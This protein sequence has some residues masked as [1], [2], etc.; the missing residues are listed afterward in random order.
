MG[1]RK[2]I[3]LIL[4]YA[5]YDK[6]TNYKE[7][8]SVIDTS[9]AINAEG[10]K[11]ISRL[12]ETTFCT[13]FDACKLFLPASFNVKL[14]TRY[15]VNEEQFEAIKALL[16][17]EDTAELQAIRKTG[18][19]HD[20]N[21]KYLISQKLIF[22]EEYIDTPKVKTEK[23]VSLTE[24]YLTGE[25][26]YAFT[27]D[28]TR[29]AVEFLKNS[30]DIT[31]KELIR[32]FDISSASLKT[33]S[34]RGVVETTAV[35]AAARRSVDISGVKAS[36]SDKAGMAGK[37]GVLSTPHKS[38]F[39]P[40]TLNSEQLQAAEGILSLIGSGKPSASLLFGVTGSGKTAVF[41]DL[42]VKVINSGKNVILL[43][44]EIALT[45]QLIKRF[46]EIFGNAI[47]CLHSGLSVSRRAEELSVI[48]AGG[49]KLLIGTRSAIFAP[50]DNIGL[51]IIDEE[52]ERTYISEMSP[53][54]DAREVAKIRTVY[55]NA[56]L[57]LASATPS[58][59]SFYYAKI[60]RYNLFTLKE[61][62][63][64][65]VLPEVNIVDI[66]S[67]GFYNDSQ[68]LSCTLV[69]EINDNLTRHEQTILLLNRRGFNTV[70]TCRS[71]KQTIMCPHCSVALTYHKSEGKLRCHWC[72]YT[73]D[74]AKVCP[75]CGSEY[76]K[77]IGS[78]TEKIEEEIAQLFPSARLLRLDADTVSGGN[79]KNSY[80]EKFAAFERQDYDILLGTQMIAKGL[81]FPNVTLIGVISVDGALY[82][83]DYRSYERTFALLTQV[84]GRGGR[85]DKPGRAVIQ[86]FNPNHY[87]LRLAAMQNY[88]EFFAEE[89]GNRKLLLYPPFCDLCVVEFTGSAD[90]KTAA[91]ASAFAKLL[92]TAAAVQINSTHEKIPLIVLGPARCI[93]ER[94]KNKFR[95]KLVIKC[96]SNGTFRKILSETYARSFTERV[97]DRITVIVSMNGDA[98]L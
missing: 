24:K 25:L 29:K 6:T 33:L 87:I 39:N 64:K 75:S 61:R 84:A 63:A 51:I 81:D 91:A 97:F 18:K 76:L 42:I 11:L 94:I 71:C 44:P 79:V 3:A 53:R 15:R 7:I 43:V 19:T 82:A 30:P 69:S 95:Y 89:I 57:V 4:S 9:P 16:S 49:C 59:E 60:G 90:E 98:S 14:K 85:G 34:K 80:D 88:P 28:K 54:Y 72:G 65:A 20:D 46:T 70:V 47:C 10:L 27:N 36:K 67:D 37:T 12:K 52:Q 31:D 96:K 5:E 68:N 50:I 77:F 40:L 78:G 2:R 48:R 1:N 58:V 26:K 32:L 83:G 17:D 38:Y 62:Y 21:V 22:P 93:R 86:S 41:T 56:A 35:K 55:H 45:P 74:E 66:A 23:I 92:K 8:L 73:R 13:Y